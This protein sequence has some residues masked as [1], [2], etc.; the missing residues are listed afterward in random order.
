MEPHWQWTPGHGGL[1]AHVPLAWAA[2]F[3]PDAPPPLTQWVRP[4]HITFL[5]RV[6]MQAVAPV[7]LPAAFLGALPS[8]PTPVLGPPIWEATRPPHPIKDA[9]HTTEERRTG[10][11]EVQNQDAF[12]AVLNDVVMHINKW[13]VA[14]GAAPIAHPEPDRFFH[15]SV[16]NNRN[17]DSMRS[18][19]DIAASDRGSPSVSAAASPHP[20]NAGGYG[21]E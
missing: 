19:G 12:H 2:P 15:I 14:H 9:G 20:G 17:G 1:L 16:W 3:L 7:P 21:V 18:I 4:L 8:L 11:L 5:H 10:F 6:S 13:R